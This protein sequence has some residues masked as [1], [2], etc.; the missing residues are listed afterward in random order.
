MVSALN[1]LEYAIKDLEIMIQIFDFW[2][3]QP[4]ADHVPLL[5]S[6]EQ[7]YA[8]LLVAMASIFHVRKLSLITNLQ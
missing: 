1:G 4:E 5:S 2:N 7:K 3:A 6:I 8:R